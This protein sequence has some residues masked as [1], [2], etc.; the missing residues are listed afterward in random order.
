M[1]LATNPEDL[2]RDFLRPY[3]RTLYKSGGVLR[4]GFFFFFVL[5]L[6]YD[7]TE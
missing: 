5:S 1:M 3:T 7:I 2:R 4:I 6:R